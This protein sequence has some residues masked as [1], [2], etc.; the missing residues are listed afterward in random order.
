MP[1]RSSTT[2]EGSG[3]GWRRT[4]SSGVGLADGTVKICATCQSGDDNR[5]LTSRRTLSGIHPFLLSNRRRGTD[6]F[7]CV[8]IFLLGYLRRIPDVRFL[9]PFHLN[10]LHFGLCFIAISVGTHHRINSSGTFHFF[11]VSLTFFVQRGSQLLPVLRQG[12]D[13][14]FVLCQSSAGGGDLFLRAEITF[15][16]DGDLFRQ[17][18]IKPL[19]SA[20][21]M[22]TCLITSIREWLS[23]AGQWVSADQVCN[24]QTLQ[25]LRDD[26]SH[27]PFGLGHT[28]GNC[29]G[30][31]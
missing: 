1:L 6:N 29:P 5:Y 4:V 22:H 21:Y 24:L 10:L 19:S 8:A 17:V 20:S 7:K 18:S 14:S 16:Q 13:L 30:L 3:R 15:V 26:L 12:I 25:V 28:H 9:E 31:L 27:V 2:G 23:S 11:T